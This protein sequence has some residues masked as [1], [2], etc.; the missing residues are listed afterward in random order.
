MKFWI[1]REKDRSPFYCFF[2]REPTPDDWITAGKDK[3]QCRNFIMRTFPC[4][5]EEATGIKLDDG[6]FVQVEITEISDTYYYA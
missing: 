1:A 3:G 4:G 5:I 2:D 6:E